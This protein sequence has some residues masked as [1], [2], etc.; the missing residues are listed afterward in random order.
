[1]AEPFPNKPMQ[2]WTAP[3]LHGWI[4]STMKADGKIAQAI[5]EGDV[6]EVR[7]WRSKARLCFEE[8]DRRLGGRWGKYQSTKKMCERVLRETSEWLKANDKGE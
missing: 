6:Q 7:Y 8:Y 3:K 2:W 1:M 4:Y 5:A